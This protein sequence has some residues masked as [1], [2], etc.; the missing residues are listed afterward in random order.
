MMERGDLA[1]WPSA[2][3]VARAHGVTIA[4]VYRLL[5]EGRLRGVQTRV[6]WLLDPASVATWA[7]ARRGAKSQQQEEAPA[8]PAC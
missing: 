3:D 8:C 6:G 4:Y 1:H 5:H 2:A 7:A